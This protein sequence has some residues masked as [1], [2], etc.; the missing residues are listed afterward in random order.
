MSISI[1]FFVKLW[2]ASQK[3]ETDGSVVELASE[4]LSSDSNKLKNMLR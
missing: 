3:F 1:N 2:P 4:K